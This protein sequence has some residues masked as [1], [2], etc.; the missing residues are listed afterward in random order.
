MTQNQVYLLQPFDFSIKFRWNL[1]QKMQPNVPLKTMNFEIS[2]F[3]VTIDEEIYKDLQ[4]LS[5]FFSWHITAM[6]K[7]MTHFK[8]RPAFNEP[9]IGNAKKY[10]KYAIKSTI[11]YLKKQE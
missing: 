7:E 1:N 4:Y 2:Q 10:W 9:I 3:L 5:K 11:Y 8:F 6:S